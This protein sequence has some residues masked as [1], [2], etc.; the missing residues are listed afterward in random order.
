VKVA[1]GDCVASTSVCQAMHIYIGNEEFIVD[2]FVIPLEGFD[3]VL[4]V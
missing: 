3:M 4:S 2:L 1:N